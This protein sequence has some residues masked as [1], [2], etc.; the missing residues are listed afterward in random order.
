ML[1]GLAYIHSQGIMH[2]DIKPANLLVD[3]TCHI[4][5]I[6]DFGSAKK[7][8]PDEASISYITSRWYRAPELI[9]GNKKYDQAVDIWSAGCVIAELL[10][11][12]PLFEG[13]NAHQQIIEVI[14]RLGTPNDD[15][16]VAMNPDEP[17]RSLPRV[18]GQGWDNIF[19][20]YVDRQSVDL[21]SRMLKYDPTERIGIWQALA[22]P[23]FDELRED[24]LLL[25][26]GNCIPDLFNF[27]EEEKA[28][29][30]SEELREVIIPSWYNP[31]TS[32]G[33]HVV[34]NKQMEQLQKI[35]KR[36]GLK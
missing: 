30:G 17:K 20:E 13:K 7:V 6:C 12:Q 31:L 10:M 21:V 9:F 29:M 15:E 33:T 36:H 4:L 24:G 32:P 1:R 25:P 5:K 34:S 11:G 35:F 27:T 2:R 23:I 3:P 19:P 18:I 26:N 8:T 28:D 22:M 14:K 16:L